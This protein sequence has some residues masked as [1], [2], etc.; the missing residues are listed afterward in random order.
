VSNAHL[1]V[2][3]SGA[4]TEVSEF[5]FS[6]TNGQA[7]LYFNFR[8]NDNAIEIYQG[9]VQRFELSAGTV[10]KNGLAAVALTSTEKTTKAYGMGKLETLNPPVYLGSPSKPAMEDAGKIVWN[11]D[12]SQGRYYKIVV[13]K[14]RK[15]GGANNWKGKFFYR[16]FYPTD[17]AATQPI[18]P[19]VPFS[20]GYFGYLKDPASLVFTPTGV[21]DGV[22]QQFFSQAQK[23]AFHVVGLKPSTTH[24]FT[25][26]GVNLTSVCLQEGTSTLGGGLV[27]S[28]N[29]ELKFDFFY[30]GGLGNTSTAFLEQ[31]SRA[32][33]TSIRKLWSIN[34]FDS[35][36]AAFGVIEAKEYT[37][38]TNQFIDAGNYERFYSEQY[39]LV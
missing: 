4:V 8:D 26:D 36:S 35:S 27:S 10:V 31:N 11:H 13:T 19:S 30:D 15:S 23:F 39:N 33:Q 37:S 29:G 38:P 7:E 24:T 3:L 1:L 6:S 22:Q 34:S 16:L 2:N 28:V 25:F 17:Q 32:G 12:A 14:Y 9:N 21:S 5:T 20:I 18:V